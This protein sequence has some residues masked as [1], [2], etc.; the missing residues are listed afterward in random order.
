MPK[1]A[2]FDSALLAEILRKQHNVVGRDQALACKI[3]AGTLGYRIRPGGPWQVAL[4]G[5]YVAQTGALSDTQRVVAAFLHA[6]PALA[7]TGTT[8]A[9]RYGIPCKPTGFIDVL[10]PVSCRRSG[11]GFARL[12]RTTVMP[13]VLSMDGI[14][15]YAAPARAIAD[16]ALQLADIADV[17]ALVAAGVQR[18]KV[19][20]WQLEEELAAGSSRGSARLRQTLAEV[21]DGVRSSA[22]GDLH[23]LIGRSRLPQPLFNPQ[24]FV[25]SEFLACPDAW[26]PEHG[27]A[28]EVDSRAWHL[29]P[30]DWEQTMARHARMAAQGIL[31]LHFPP[32][33]IRAE[34]WQVVKRI[35]ETLDASRGPLPHIVAV[36]ASRV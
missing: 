27:V 24:L 20:I 14:V 25:G 12:H 31:V 11:A 26:W 8:A 17:R 21:A 15:R 35:S 19:T 32:R 29:S 28:A 7:V 36:P 18:G 6:G 13:Q 33:Q 30:A 1:M 22:E 2:E 9:A 16:A 3:S 5:V 10:V 4:P 34:G 23:A